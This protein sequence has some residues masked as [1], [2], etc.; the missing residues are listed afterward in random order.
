LP[1]LFFTTREVALTALT[2]CAPWWTTAG[3]RAGMG[4]TYAPAEHLL[5]WTPLL[6]AISGCPDASAGIDALIITLQ[7]ALETDALLFIFR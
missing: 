5:S 3:S 6:S 4:T 2:N 1:P 7:P